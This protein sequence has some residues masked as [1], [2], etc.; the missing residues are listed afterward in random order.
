M[1][2]VHE[3]NEFR[4][5]K[6]HHGYVNRLRRNLLEVMEAPMLDRRGTAVL[7][8]LQPAALI[9]HHAPNAY[10]GRLLSPAGAS[11]ACSISV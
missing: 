11:P 6:F 7:D 3:E 5:C 2:L 8:P 9:C 1:P 10:H 4:A